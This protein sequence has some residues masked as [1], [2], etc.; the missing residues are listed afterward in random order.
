MTDIE[1][2]KRKYA[3]DHLCKL[4]GIVR[5]ECEEVLRNGLDWQKTRIWVR[6]KLGKEGPAHELLIDEPSVCRMVFEEDE[7]KELIILEGFGRLSEDLS[8]LD[9]YDL[10]LNV[11]Q[12]ETHFENTGIL[13]GRGWLVAWYLPL[14]LGAKRV[15]PEKLIISLLRTMR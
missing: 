4:F 14:I 8:Q 2:M 9:E 11:R 5:P 10:E 6:N 7:G 3:I 15:G 13:A 12:A 1:W